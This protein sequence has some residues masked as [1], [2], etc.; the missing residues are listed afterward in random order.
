LICNITVW[1]VSNS[2]DLSNTVSETDRM[3]YA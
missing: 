3:I 1:Y 2:M